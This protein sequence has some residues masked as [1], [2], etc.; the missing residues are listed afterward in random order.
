MFLIEQVVIGNQVYAFF[1]ALDHYGTNTL[2]EVRKI[3]EDVY[4]DNSGET[5][6]LVLDKNVK[7]LV[8]TQ[9][10][11]SAGNPWSD[12]Y[13]FTSSG[14]GGAASKPIIET[15]D[16]AASL[17]DNETTDYSV[18]FYENVFSGYKVAKGSYIT[19][20][21]ATARAAA[22]ARDAARN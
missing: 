18:S 21:M 12:W 22:L 17:A 16:Q 11:D 8:R 6:T 14:D 9:N 13:S 3:A 19:S 7:Y 20:T 4:R 15:I 10:N 5:L 2:W 1:M